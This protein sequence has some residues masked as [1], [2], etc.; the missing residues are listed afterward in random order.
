M[1]LTGSSRLTSS[2]NHDAINILHICGQVGRHKLRW[3]TALSQAVWTLTR[4][5]F[6]WVIKCV[7][8]NF[9]MRSRSHWQLLNSV[10][11]G[12]SKNCSPGHF[13][14]LF[15][16]RGPTQQ[17]CLAQGETR[18]H[19]SNASPVLG[20]ALRH[21][22]NPAPAASGCGYVTAA[23]CLRQCSRP[24]PDCNGPGLNNA[25]KA[26]TSFIPSGKGAES[27]LSFLVIQAETPR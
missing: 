23:P 4:A 25:T 12:S 16:T 17:V 1:A 5:W 19:L 27:D 21:K 6:R 8:A 7:P 20:K 2:I 10:L 18:Q 22:W 11:T 26:M 9:S 3:I 13:F 14:G 24:L 15:L